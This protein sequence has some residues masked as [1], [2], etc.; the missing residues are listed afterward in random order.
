M[1]ENPKDDHY[2]VWYGRRDDRPYAHGHDAVMA[3]YGPQMAMHG[4]LPDVLS[5]DLGCDFY[6]IHARNKTELEKFRKYLGETK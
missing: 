6:S 5:S 3:E 1:P 2:C 4:R